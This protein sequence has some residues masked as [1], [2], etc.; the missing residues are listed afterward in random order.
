MA[1]K[2]KDGIRIGTVDVINSSGA[3]LVKSPSSDKWAAA[4]TVTFATGDVTGS[5]SIDGSGDVGNVALTIAANSVAL[6]TDTTGDYLATATAGTGISLSG[7]GTEGRALTITNSDLGSSQNIFKNIANST[8]T[9]Q[10][11]AAS[12]SDTIRFAGTG[13]TTVSFDS[14]TKTITI[15]STGAEFSAGSGISI[16]TGTIAVDSTVVRTTGTQ[17]IAGDK[18]FSNNVVIS[19]NLTVDGTT[20]TVNSTTISVDDK[21]I[22][23]GSVSSP[24]DTTADGGGITL[25]GTTDKTINW[26]DATDAWTSSEHFNIATGKAYYINGTSVLSSNT[27]GSGVT[28]SSLTSV[29]TIGTG[30]WQGTTV[31][32]GYGGTGQTTYSDGQLLIGNSSGGL[33]KATLTAGSNVTITNG[34]GTISIA[35]TDTTY[36]EISQAETVDESSTATRLISGRRLEYAFQNITAANAT[37][38]A[39]AAVVETT[40]SAT[41]DTT[42]TVATTSITTVDTF[43]LATFRSGRYLIQ[44]T[45]GSDYQVSE[46][47]VIHD[48]TTTYFTEYAVLETNGSL[49]TFTSDVNG[50]DARI[51]VTMF[52]ATSS[53]IRVSR[54]LM[55]V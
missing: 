50:T 43:P 29:G 35:S 41:A 17:S 38:A 25:K 37:N 23:L 3:L 27:L 30:T 34:N 39:K 9:T 48:G 26:V 44:V 45:Q 36:S 8:G 55:K 28:A 12:N 46:L 47:R 14:G 54:H 11:S 49:A 18:T 52:S 13:S 24:S 20:T 51:R 21:N 40:Y 10:F 22:E 19:G 15:D 42:A 32:V 2:I 5:F 6:G 1:F 7:S 4:R 53:T 31:G 16:S 33:S